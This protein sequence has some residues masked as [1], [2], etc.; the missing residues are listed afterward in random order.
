MESGPAKRRNRV[1]REKARTGPETVNAGAD[2]PRFEGRPKLM[3]S[4]ERINSIRPAG[5]LATACKQ[6]GPS[7]T[8]EV[9]VVIAVWINWQ[10][11]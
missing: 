5:V 8:R 6:S 4:Y 9:P 11:A 10:L 7:A 3:E 1:R 2:P